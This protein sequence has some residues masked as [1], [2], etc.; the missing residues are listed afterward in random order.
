MKQKKK[1]KKKKA[2]SF[3]EIEVSC[4]KLG[5]NT[6]KKIQFQNNFHQ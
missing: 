5:V 3:S 6:L 1:R 4:N 2:I